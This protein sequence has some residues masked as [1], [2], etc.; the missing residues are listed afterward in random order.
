MRG[1][2]KN[3]SWVKAWAQYANQV[4]R[5]HEFHG[6]KGAWTERQETDNLHHFAN[7]PFSLGDHCL[8]NGQH[9]LNLGYT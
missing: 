2:D 4:S 7:G 6:G 1:M 3:A 5:W 9:L 8:V